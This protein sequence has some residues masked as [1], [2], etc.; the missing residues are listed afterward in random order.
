MRGWLLSVTNLSIPSCK[1]SDV[2]SKLPSMTIALYSTLA[3][4][5]PAGG[6][7]PY[8]TSRRLAAVSIFNALFSLEFKA[9]YRL[10]IISAITAI[11]STLS[12]PKDRSLH[13]GGS[14]LAPV[15]PRSEDDRLALTYRASASRDYSRV[16]SVLN[17]PMY[18]SGTLIIAASSSACQYL[19]SL[20]SNRNP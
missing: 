5:R 19:I 4:P 3:I 11:A 12:G 1:V 2:S 10:D 9:P 8:P 18:G 7:S 20:S 13:K 6:V 17:G 14:A 16:V 15:V